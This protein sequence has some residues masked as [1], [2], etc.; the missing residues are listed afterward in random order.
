MLSHLLEEQGA[1]F[2]AF[3]AIVVADESVEDSI[4]T[5][6]KIDECPETPALSEFPDQTD[7]GTVVRRKA[8]G[9]GKDGT[10]VVL[11]EIEGGGHTWPGQK[12]PLALIGKSTLDVSANDLM[13]E[14]FQKHPVK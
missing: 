7:D 3:E 13:W 14:F 10:E 1:T 4:R 2:Q 6:C 8:Y 9:P 11:I 5:W 12:S